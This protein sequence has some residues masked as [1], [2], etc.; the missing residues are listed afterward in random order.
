VKTGF[1][2]PLAEVVGRKGRIAS[3]IEER[4]T[5]RGLITHATLIEIGVSPR[6][7]GRRCEDRSLIRVHRGVYFVG[8]A[9][10]TPLARAEA[11]VLACGPRAALSHDSAAA[12]YRLR[13]WP[14]TPEISSAVQHKRSGIRTHQ[15][16]TLT[17]AD[18]TTR[19]GIRVTTPVRTLADIAP[20]LT[21][22]QLTRAIHEA[23]RN[24]DLN[25]LARLIDACSR[26]RQ[27]IDPGHAPSESGLEDDF[28]AFLTE[29][30][31]PFPEFQV[32][33][34][35]FR[36]DALYA[37]QKLIVE[38]DGPD[39]GQ[40]DRIEQD[41]LRDALALELGFRTLRITRRRLRQAPDLARQMR[42]IL[43]HE[44]ND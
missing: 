20:R 28:R 10:L 26:A 36:L 22:R 44:A 6:G 19:E 27:L 15:T 33:W 16:T 7:I 39:H 25:D 37:E 8:H 24:G 5:A 11:A 43:A 12:L 38:I 2:A 29:Y 23:R 30:D 41:H 17:R 4:A 21:D 35:G 14:P 13:R 18:V 3:E 42:V 34:H 1:R 9:E 32:S 31:L 40:W